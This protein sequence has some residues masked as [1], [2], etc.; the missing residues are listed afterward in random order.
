MGV[1][2]G[3]DG[4]WL[5]FHEQQ[6]A[7]LDE[8]EKQAVE[9]RLKH[10]EE[11]KEKLAEEKEAMREIVSW[12]GDELAVKPNRWLWRHRFSLGGL[13]IVAGKGEVS[14]STLVACYIAWLTTGKMKGTYYGTP[15]DVACIVNEDQ[16]EQTVI[17]RLI[18]N[19]ADLSRVHFLKVGILGREEVPLSFPADSERLKAFIRQTGVVATFID[20]L[21]SNIQGNRNDQGDMRRVFENVAKIAESTGTAI[22]GLAHTRKAKAEDVVEAIMGSSEQANVSR[23]VHG[24]VMDPEEDGARILSCEKNN[25]YPR[26]LLPTLRFRLESIDVPCTDGSG[27]YNSQPRIEWLEEIS[28]TASD[29]LGDALYGT[30]GVDECARWLYDYLMANGGEALLSDIRNAIPKGKKWGDQMLTRARGKTSIKTRRL[31]QSQP[32]SVWYFPE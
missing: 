12:R 2:L 21:S 7:D 3:P 20:P 26:H 25:G 18:V 9:K 16:L 11:A 8:K 14:K 28:E 27:D 29:I 30:N 13:S 10:T 6:L 23:S 31:R 24:L 1:S 15:V 4:L 5:T 19:G 17:P 22:V 32:G